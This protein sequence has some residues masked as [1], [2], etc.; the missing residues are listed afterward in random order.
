MK[1]II[2]VVAL[3]VAGITAALAQETYTITVDLTGMKSN[4]GELYI[5]L[6]NKED[7]FLK[8]PY[9]TVK[10]KIKDLKATIVLTDIVKG[11]YAISVFQDEN[12]NQKMD[13]NFFGIPKEA[14]GTSNDAKGFMGP[15]KYKDAKFSVNKNVN[16]KIKMT[17]IF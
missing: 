15:P 8:V 7:A 13:T 5:A 4:K 12:N 10:T 3:W 17:K 1:Q 11:D 2:L 9:K 14:I 16:L 6:Y